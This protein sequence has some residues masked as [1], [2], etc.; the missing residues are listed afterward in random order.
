MWL[1]STRLKVGGARGPL[2]TPAVRLEL[3]AG[4]HQRETKETGSRYHG[5]GCP[6]GT[7]WEERRK[8][9]W[10]GAAM[11]GGSEVTDTNV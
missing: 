8:P 2:Q 3:G 9:R 11:R 10:L 5:P 7:F 4:I 1:H 6:G